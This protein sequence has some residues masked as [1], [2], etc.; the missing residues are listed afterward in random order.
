MHGVQQRL[1]ERETQAH[2]LV[3]SEGGHAGADVPRDVIDH[4]GNH[5]G[6]GSHHEPRFGF[7]E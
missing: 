4:R 6:V 3:V 2:Q 1:L 5:R 7:D